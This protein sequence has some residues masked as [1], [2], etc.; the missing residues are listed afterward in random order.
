VSWQAFFLDW[1]RSLFMLK[2]SELGQ[3]KLK[4]LSTKALRLT[5]QYGM[6]T[7]LD[8]RI[9]ATDQE[10]ID[11]EVMTPRIL[12]AAQKEYADAGFI[13]KGED[14]YYYSKY[15]AVSN[16]NPKGYNYINFFEFF[17]RKTFYTMYKRSLNFFFYILSS[18]VP[19]TYHN[20]AAEHLYNNKTSNKVAVDYFQNFKDMAKH[21]SYQV[22]AGFLEVKLGKSVFVNKDGSDLKGCQERFMEALYKFC[23][24]TDA[25]TRKKRM[26]NASDLHI[27]KI[28]VVNDNPLDVYKRRATFKD[29]E[30]IAMNNGFDLNDYDIELLKDVHKLKRKMFDEFGKMGVRIYR[31]ALEHYFVTGGHGFDDDMSSGDFARILAKNYIAPILKL[32]IQTYFKEYA[33]SID[34][35]DFG[36]GAKSDTKSYIKV[37]S[38][39][40]YKDDLVLLDRELSSINIDLHD[41]LTFESAEWFKFKQAVIDVFKQEKEI[42]NNKSAVY[43][44]AENR[45]LTSKKRQEEDEA[46][47]KN[48]ST[49]DRDR[50][51][52]PFY[53]WLEK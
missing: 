34:H 27:L 21:L 51:V 38:Q 14:G 43:Y 28:R 9:Y 37:F 4:T 19:G 50:K 8:G 45:Q 39:M 17:N 7:D 3:A 31:Q 26:K 33:I 32:N 13:E 15:H 35:Q 25:S 18:K 20:V 36:I 49:P 30:I 22:A 40:A 52:V 41:H 5:T 1:E 44:L 46:A 53:N 29:L 42:G 11:N 10:L 24:K 23:G 16:K 2:K 6:A 48:S 12:P 47:F